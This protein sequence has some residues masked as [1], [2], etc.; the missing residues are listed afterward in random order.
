MRVLLFSGS[1]PRHLYVHDAIMQSDVEC[2]AVVMERESLMPTPPT[3]IV[4]KDKDNFVR[5][6]KERDKAEQKVFATTTPHDLFCDIPVHYC[7]P[8]SLNS[9][10]TVNFVRKFNP[11]MVFIF[12]VDIIK[13]PLLGVLPKDKVNLHLGLSPLYRGS[14]TLFWPFYFMQPQYAGVTFHQI[15]PEADAGDIVH[16]STPE[17]KKGDGIHDV[18]VRAVVQAKLDL[19]KLMNIYL[20]S[21]KWE[22][23]QQRSSG[24]LFLTND[25]EPHHLRVIYETFDNNIVDYYLKNELGGKVPLLIH[26]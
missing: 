9:D 26:Q 18:G 2:S 8:D 6:F 10:V 25:F 1:H 13:D 22:T 11:D 5:H 3:G 24:R 12:G 14:A 4:S 20:K 21:F 7:K 15:V 23:Y 17:L 19:V 16:Q